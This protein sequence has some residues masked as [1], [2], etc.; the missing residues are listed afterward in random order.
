M[1]PNV[2]SFHDPATSTFS[3]VVYG[4]VGGHAAV[5]DPV[6]DYDRASGGLSTDSADRLLAFVHEHRL[7][8][9][10]I[11]ETHAH[12]DHLTAAGYLKQR[13]GAKVAIG[14]GILAVRARFGP[15]DGWLPQAAD[16]DH[17]F[18]RLFVDGDRFAIGTLDA[19]VIATPGH[20][21]DSL[22]YLIGDAAFV[23]DT[24]FSPASGTA[25]SDFP[26][27]DAH[28]LYRSIRR[29]LALPAQT[30]LFLCHDYPPTGLSASF[31]S[32][33]L[34]QANENIH[35]LAAQDEAS[36]VELRKRRDAKLALPALIG[37]ALRMNL[38]AGRWPPSESDIPAI[39]G[40]IDTTG[41]P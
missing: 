24:V 8:V 5:I 23:G 40:R 12:A 6:L 11:L 7:T 33:P 29:L 21:E 14:R 28:A 13:T 9:Q 10:W 27:G 31:E 25:R 15:P 16:D 17:P 26:G 4:H 37:P 39:G 18:D 36:F 41:A 34:A 38:Q 30:R 20:T 35:L 19:Q 3:H 32:T 2:A 22:T 1:N